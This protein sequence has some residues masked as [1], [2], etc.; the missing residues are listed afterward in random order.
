MRDHG[1]KIVGVREHDI[2]L[3]EIVQRRRESSSCIWQ[4]LGM[5]I[6]FP[7]D[8]QSVMNSRQGREASVLNSRVKIPMVA[9]TTSIGTDCEDVESRKGSFKAFHIISNRLSG[10]SV[11]QLRF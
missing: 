7:K 1:P 6:A 8:G 11:L 3:A 2:G 4:R 5:G 9:S 10:P